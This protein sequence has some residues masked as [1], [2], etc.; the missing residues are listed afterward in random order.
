MKLFKLIAL[1]S[2]FINFINCYSFSGRFIQNNNIINKSEGRLFN[3]KLYYTRKRTMGIYARFMNNIS[4]RDALLLSSTIPFVLNNKPVEAKNINIKKVAVFGSTGYTGGDTIRNLI[5]RNI[6][7]IAFTR[8]KVNIVDKENAG[9]DTLVI[10]NIEQKNSLESIVADVLK[11]ETLVNKLKDVDAVI[12]CAG[13]K[14]KVTAKPI[15]GVK[16]KN[17]NYFNKNN[18]YDMSEVDSK[19]VEESNHV[20][21]VGLVNVAREAIKHNVKKLV[22]VSSICSNCQ[23]NKINNNK[24]AGEVTDKGETSCEICYN[25]QEGEELIKLMYEKAPSTLSY[26]IIRPGM[27]TP[28]EKRGAEEIEFNQGVSKSG[29]ISRMDL[30][31]ILVEASLS[32][33]SNKK[34]FEV[35]YRD[36][37]Q[38]VDMYKSLKTCKE[39]N[40]SVKECFFGEE[41]KDSKEELSIDKLL[42]TRQKGIIFPSGFEVIGKDYD[43]M[44]SKL[45]N[46][47]KENYDY[48]ILKSNDIM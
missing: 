13:S 22:V 9:P 30:S 38:P 11:P 27:L 31:E 20:E 46:D 40:K 21:D 41:Y 19:Y 14:P 2:I 25:K 10:D 24:I 33:N 17:S 48:N 1:S 6:N 35:Y 23:K 44:F 36:T 47:K 32:D 39:M 45:K 15:P 26:T 3:N 4:R 8:R 28:G 18:Y 37:A 43:D 42:K 16:L 29:M 34:T 5:N 12:Y 7:V